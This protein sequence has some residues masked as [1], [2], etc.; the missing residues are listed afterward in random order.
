MT[1]LLGLYPGDHGILDN[2]MWDRES[3]KSFLLGDVN[4]EGD[5]TEDPIWWKDHVPFW[6]TATKA[7]I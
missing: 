3:G 6:T 1:Q 7:G 2:N 5:Q 4:K